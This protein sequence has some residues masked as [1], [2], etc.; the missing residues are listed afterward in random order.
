MVWLLFNI[1][2]LSHCF[3]GIYQYIGDSTLGFLRR[4]LKNCPD[5]CKR[6]AYIALI[7]TLNIGVWCDTLGF[8]Q[9][10]RHS[11]TRKIQRQAA[12]LIKMTTSP[13]KVWWLRARNASGPEV[14][15][16]TT[17]IRIETDHAIYKIGRDMV[18]AI[19]A[20]EVLFQLNTKDKSEPKHINAAFLQN[21]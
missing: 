18:P 6:L 4:N 5:E 19:N 17:Q 15:T 1:P 16:T 8:V 13:L 9:T 21:L 3:R 2:L 12:R 14:I 11:V 10:T 20:D 7:N